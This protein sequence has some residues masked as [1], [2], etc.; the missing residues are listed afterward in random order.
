LPLKALVSGHWKNFLGPVLLEPGGIDERLAALS[1]EVTLDTLV[2]SDVA[3]Q[4]AFLLE[5]LKK[6]SRV[7][8]GR[9]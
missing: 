8:K 9:C 6:V 7:T 2:R 1:A 5:T 3:V 4:V